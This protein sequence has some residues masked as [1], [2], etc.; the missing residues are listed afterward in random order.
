MSDDPTI[1]DAWEIPGVP[2]SFQRLWV[3]HR[4]GYLTGTAGR[5]SN[6]CVFCVATTLDEEESLV[7]Y[8]GVHSYV[9]LNLF[10]YNPGHL[11]ICPYRHIATYDETTEEESAEMAAL[12]K[13]SM[14]LLSEVANA[15]GFNIG[16]NQGAV[17]GAGIEA[18][19][20]QHVVPRWHQDSNFFPIIA[21]TRA[22]PQTLGDV[23]DQLRQAWSQPLD[24]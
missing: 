9:V 17:A 1:R 15:H 3:P 23:R 8:T 13:R 19:L 12:T 10:P 21:H 16:M 24:S 5:K 22:M 18:H 7:V 2:D 20:H 11:L 4:I 14:V 6:E